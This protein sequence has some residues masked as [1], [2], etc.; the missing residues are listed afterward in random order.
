MTS[1]LKK[2]REKQKRQKFLIICS[3]QPDMYEDS[4]WYTE[5]YQRLCGHSQI[6]WAQNTKNSK[7]PVKYWNKSSASNIRNISL[8]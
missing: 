1:R 2:D 4:E 7:T 5:F 8:D 3:D 6:Y